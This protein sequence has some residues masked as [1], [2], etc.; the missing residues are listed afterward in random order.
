[1][2]KTQLEVTTMLVAEKMAFDSTRAYQGCEKTRS[3]VLDYG[4]V[5]SDL[6]YFSARQS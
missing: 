3:T 2:R 4:V 1:M 5:K 6:L